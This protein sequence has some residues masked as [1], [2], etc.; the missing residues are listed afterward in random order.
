[1]AGAVKIKDSRHP[2]VSINHAIS[3]AVAAAPSVN[4]V[5][6][7]PFGNAHPDTGNQFPI[8][9]PQATGNNGACT[10]PITKRSPMSVV[11]MMVVD[12]R[13]VPGTR[14]VTNVR[15]PHKTAIIVNARR[16]PTLSPKMPPGN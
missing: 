11:S 15:I 1:M 7:N 12:A 3:G 4:P 14:P 13:V 16:D 10:T 6:V 9:P 8:V 5:L 2:N